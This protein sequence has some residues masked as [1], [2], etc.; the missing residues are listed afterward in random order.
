MGLEGSQIDRYRILHLLG[1]GAMGDVYLAEDPRIGQQVAIKV[2]RVEPD[3][4][5]DA[6]NAEEAARLFQREIEAIVKLDSPHIL[7]L[8]DY[9]EQ[10]VG[11]MNIIYLVMPYRK[12]G[13]LAKWLSQRKTAEPLS[14]QEV[15]DLI[16][17]V[18]EA[19]QHAHNRQVIHRDVKPSNLLL[20]LHEETPSCPD[21]LLADF[22]VAQLMTT[23]S[24]I[25]R[26]IRGTPIYMA[27]EQWT[28]GAVPASDQYALAIMTYELLT[29]YPPFRGVALQ[30]MYQHMH[31]QPPAPGTQNPRLSREIDEV[32]LRALAKKANERFA[33][34]SA[35]ARAF[36]EA[37]NAFSAGEQAIPTVLISS[38]PEELRVVL[39]I[40]ETEAQA[41]AVRTI[42]LPGGREVTVTLPAGIQHGSLVRLG[43]QNTDARDLAG[44]VLLSI[45]IK[46]DTGALPFSDSLP[47][48]SLLSDKQAP[49]TSATILQDQVPVTVSQQS[50]LI[51]SKPDNDKLPILSSATERPHLTNQILPESFPATSGKDRSRARLVAGSR[52]RVLFAI[53]LVTLI[54]L[55][56]GSLIGSSLIRSSTSTTVVTIT[57]AKKGLQHTYTILAVTSTPDSAKQQ[58][59]ARQLT[60]VTAPQSQTVQ[61]TGTSTQGTHASGLLTLYNYST[62]SSV[63]LNA[64][65][66]IANTQS[67]PVDMI[68]DAAV[69]AP[70]GQDASNPGTAHVPA[71]VVQP[72]TIGNLPPVNNGDAGFYSCTNCPNGKVKGYEIENDAAFSGGQNSQTVTTVQQSDIDNAANKLKVANAPNP[73]QIFQAQVRTNEQLI[74]SAQCKPNISSNPAAGAQAT[75]VTVT[76]TFTCTGEVYDQSAALAL[77]QKLLMNQAKGS[78]GPRY[79]LQGSIAATE[80][81]AVLTD[82]K[83]G[84]I[85]LTASTSG[86]WVTH[87]DDTYLQALAV[88]I[89]GKTRQEAQSIL[90][91]N[92][93]IV[94][95]DIQIS[96]SNRDILPTDVHQIRIVINPLAL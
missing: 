64:G 36:Q 43:E 55:L 3:L 54:L 6:L 18:A 27:P 53:G 39:A 11:E 68:L 75:S 28:G 52:R 22:G 87:F 41:G 31:N 40:S 50:A 57:P 38:P 9:G 51:S 42:T 69:T 82:T 83:Q 90:S 20:R 13:S 80:T 45:V 44:T 23:T 93:D 2:I 70:P 24:N 94:S 62:S 29:G 48:T 1:S 14:P 81:R 74:N 35:F 76:V 37:V 71:H 15:A 77:A 47:I 96:G 86:T 59:A 12:E 91:A 34:V 7:P 19:L 88:S 56:I 84:T 30:I 66:Q 95:A 78:F 21:I 46:Q 26:S 16:G 10:P 61:A 79:T 8:Y 65:M 92:K 67:T 5:P 72:G 49:T 60:V 89:A 25:S 32:L 33:S 4:Y 63:T 85:T 73:R 58:I 17:Q